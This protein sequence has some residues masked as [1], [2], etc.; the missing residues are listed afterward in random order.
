MFRVEC[1]CTTLQR[2]RD[3][4]LRVQPMPNV[5]IEIESVQ[6]AIE[7]HFTGVPPHQMHRRFLGALS[8]ADIVLKAQ[9]AS[10]ES[11]IRRHLFHWT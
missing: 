9:S 8:L 6:L 3:V 2:R 11:E 5:R 4:A 10:A 1:Q 7:S